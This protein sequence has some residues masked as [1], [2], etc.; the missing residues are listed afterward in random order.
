MPSIITTL[1]YFVVPYVASTLF[2]AVIFPN[3]GVRIVLWF[4]CRYRDIH[5]KL[6]ETKLHTKGRCNY[7]WPDSHPIFYISF[8]SPAELCSAA[9]RTKQNKRWW[10]SRVQTSVQT[11]ETKLK[12]HWINLWVPSNVKIKLQL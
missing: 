10:V 11:V 5:H 6:D 8:K 1:P 2:T 4:L 7:G 9:E 12:S 3:K